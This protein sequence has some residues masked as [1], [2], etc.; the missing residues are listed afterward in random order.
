VALVLKAR[1]AKLALAFLECKAHKA[2][3]AKPDR[4]ATKV[5]PA[6]LGAKAQLGLPGKM[7][8]PE[9][10]GRLDLLVL[11]FLERK[12]HRGQL[13]LLDKTA[14]SATKAQLARLAKTDKQAQQELESKAR[15]VLT[16]SPDK[17]EIKGRLGLLALAYLEHKDH[18]AQQANRAKLEKP[19][20]KDLQ[21]L[22]DKTGKL[23]MSGVLARKVGKAQ[24]EPVVLARKVLRGLLVLAY[25][26]HKDHKAQPVTLVRLVS[27]A[28]QALPEK[29]AR[30]DLLERLERRA[31]ACK[32]QQVTL[33]KLAQLEI[34]AQLDLLEFL[35]LSVHRAC[36]GRQVTSSPSYLPPRAIVLCTVW[37]RPRS[38]SWTSCASSI[39]APNRPSPLTHSSRKCA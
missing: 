12:A 21:D 1:P 39:P 17:L 29:S 22:L 19:V 31:S 20:I 14:L 35:G 4:L 27:K 33:E 23:A 30:L 37:S 13:V 28:Q 6:K 5:Q 15:Q 25:L 10:K 9:I 32:G 34:K 11:V 36:K 7:G 2:Q 3:L 24:R 18:K 16:D 26:E 8:R 38:C